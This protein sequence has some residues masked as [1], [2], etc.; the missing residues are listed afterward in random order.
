MESR[1][2]QASYP[3]TGSTILA[4]IL[5]GIFCPDESIHPSAT[6]VRPNK[7]VLAYLITKVHWEASKGGHEFDDWI[8][9]YSDYDLYFIVSNRRGFFPLAVPLPAYMKRY[10]SHNNIL[11]IEY[12]D[13]L[14]TKENTV[15]KIVKYTY[16]QLLSFLPPE[17]FP[18]IEEQ[19]ILDKAIT[20]IEN[21]NELYETIKHKPFEYHDDF[22]HIHGSHRGRSQLQT[23]DEN[24]QSDSINP[25]SLYQFKK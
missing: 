21:M 11:F 13:L 10:Y 17:L 23:K 22:F 6:G 24:E 4:N 15:D 19:V 9:N 14:E 16:E 12:K 2:I 3:G 7:K 25:L 1:I 5:S 20:R 18:D 8:E